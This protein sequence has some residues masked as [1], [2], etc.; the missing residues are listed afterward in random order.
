MDEES[1]CPELVLNEDNLSVIDC[2][3]YEPHQF[4]D[5]TKNLSLKYFS[6]FGSNIRSCRKN[7]VALESFL[8]LFMYKLSVIVLCETWLLKSIDNNFNIT[9]YNQLNL[10]RS[11]HGGGLK[12]FYDDSF[13]SNVIQECTVLNDFI[14]VVTFY[15]IGGNFKYIICSIYR[16]P[17]G[18]ITSFNRF[19]FNDILSKFANIHQIIIIGDININLFNPLKLRCVNDYMN[20]MMEFGFFPV[21][22]KAAKINSGNSI[23]QFSLI[24]QIWVNFKTGI[25]H[26]AGIVKVPITDHYPVF[27]LFD[28]GSFS[29]SKYTRTRKVTNHYINNF[30]D[31]LNCLN[32]DYFLQLSPLNAIKYFYETLYNMYKRCCPI[33]KVKIKSKMKNAAWMTP[34]LKFCIKKKYRLFNLLR[35]GLISRHQFNKYKNTLIYVKNKMKRLYMLKEFSNCNNSKETWSKINN[36]LG[37]HKNDQEVRVVDG[38][39]R[40]L[41][42]MDLANHFNNYF[43]SLPHQLVSNL[44]PFN[45]GNGDDDVIDSVYRNP[46]SFFFRPT[47]YDEVMNTINS[48]ENKGNPLFDITPRILKKI[49]IIIVP[50]LVCIYNLCITNG[51]YP[52]F[53]KLARVVPVFKAGQ[54]DNVANYRPISNLSSLNKLF[55]RLTHKRLSSFLDNFNIISHSQYGFRKLKCTALANFHIVTDLMKTFHDKHYTV[56][57][58]LDLKRAFDTVDSEI[59]LKKLEYCGIRDSSNAFFRS[60]LTNRSQFVYING[61]KSDKRTIN[62]GVPQ[63][64]ILGPA[65]FNI[66][67]NDIIDY[68]GYNSVFYADDGVF[69]VT[70]ETLSG[71]VD[72]MNDLIARL[73]HWLLV[74]RLVPN[75]S[76]TKVMLFT[77]RRCNDLPDLMFNGTNLLWVRSIKYL[78]VILDEKLNF[79]EHVCTLLG[80]L[81]QANGILYSMKYSAPTKVKLNIYY[82]LVYSIL[83]QNIIVWGGLSYEHRRNIQIGMNKILRQILCVNY[84]ENHRPLVS[85]DEMYKKLNLLKFDDIYD[86]F[87]LKFIHFVLYK[88]RRI[89]D[90]YF[91]DLLPI[92]NYETRNIRI[93]LPQ[94]RLD[95]EKRGTIFQVCRLFNTIHPPLLVQQSGYK[96]KKTFKEICLSRY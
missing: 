43:I 60:Y 46:N 77:S 81:A 96:L 72:M 45:D 71:C 9:G 56:A 75:L 65:L 12:I 93:N 89:F 42:E 64:S 26:A 1:D 25:S 62:V 7:F 41:Q 82:S 27:Y 16:P 11:T 69:Y 57:L 10:Y 33:K 20:G 95:I 24:D 29:V 51:L 28:R 70:S 86:F 17:S 74:N 73:S 55:E 92:H 85:T 19:L 79:F 59:L 6:I 5:Y 44:P 91:N 52:D 88:D 90:N 54:R 3:Y 22:S 2:S 78:G 30:I 23:T 47:S 67:I 15:L 35:R 18:C 13:I 66:F 48:L 83:T 63:G 39:G 76:K 94:I 34:Q 21:I 58:F 40:C 32:F 53:L 8:S 49:S 36:F 87:L 4:I 37:R 84:D 80:K 50:Y 31:S 38:D 61:S 68:V 14:E